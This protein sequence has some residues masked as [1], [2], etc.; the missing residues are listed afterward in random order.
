MK[1]KYIKDITN[2][3]ADGT[4]SDTLAVVGEIYEVGGFYL[5]TYTCLVKGEELTFMEEEVEEVI[6]HE[7]KRT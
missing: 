1:V 4:S 7:P 2:M 5:G 3:N 6:E